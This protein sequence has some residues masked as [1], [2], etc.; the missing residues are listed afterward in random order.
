MSFQTFCSLQQWI[1]DH[2]PPHNDSLQKIHLYPRYE[3]YYLDNTHTDNNLFS[4]YPFHHHLPAID[5]HSS[6]INDSYSDYD[7]N[8][9][10][11]SDYDSDYY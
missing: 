5:S 4:T 3:D 8:S 6:Q 2:C 7:S 9:D 1:A 11:N 10:Y